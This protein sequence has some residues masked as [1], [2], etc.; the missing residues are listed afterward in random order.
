MD[1]D[2][3]VDCV[4]VVVTVLGVV[5]V[6][7]RV[8]ICDMVVDKEFPDTEAVVVGITVWV[9][10]E[11]SVEV[12]GG[13]LVTVRRDPELVNA[14]MVVVIGLEVVLGCVSVLVDVTSTAAVCDEGA[15]RVDS[16]VS[17]RGL[18][19]V[20]AADWVGVLVLPGMVCV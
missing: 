1:C 4:N 7:V 3:V 5:S 9:P 15:L 16:T 2:N 11:E 14:D 18:L 10:E 8:D 13:E 20:D 12:M 6:C 17:D 19:S